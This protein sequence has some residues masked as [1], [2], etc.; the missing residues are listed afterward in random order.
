MTEIARED[1][2]HLARLSSLELSE[3]EISGLQ[4]DIGNI[5]G[6]VQ[7]LGNLDTKGVE[8]TY[9]VTGLQ[10]VW[11]DNDTVIDYGVTREQLLK[12]APQSADNQVK[13]PK[14]L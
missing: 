4:N 9:Q 1:V 7:Q 13:V 2:L 6:Y 3:D 5:L 10:N 8:P 12:R 14:V 11:R